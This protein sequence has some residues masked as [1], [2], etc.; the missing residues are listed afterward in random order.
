MAIAQSNSLLELKED[1]A[2][3]RHVSQGC[4]LHDLLS[5][6]KSEGVDY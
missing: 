6:A 4:G 5:L 1:S 3:P 2:S